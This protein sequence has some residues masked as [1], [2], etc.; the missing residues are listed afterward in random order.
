MVYEAMPEDGGAYECVAINNAGEARC[1]AEVIVEKKPTAKQPQ[2]Q[3]KPQQGE[4]QAPQVVEPMQ[5]MTRNEGQAVLFRCKLA[6]ASRKS[7]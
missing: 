5:D 3:K 4:K 6:S 2:Q 1:E 7:A